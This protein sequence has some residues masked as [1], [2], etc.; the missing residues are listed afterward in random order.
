MGTAIGLVLLSALAA[1]SMHGIVRHLGQ[2]L[3]PFQIAF[4]RFALGGVILLPW[5]M[6]AG[7]LALATSRIRLH[8]LRAVLN[9]AAL[10]CFFTALTLAPLAQLVALNFT[11]PL[12]ASLLAIVMLR[13]RIRLRRTLGLAAGFAGMLV[14]LRPDLGIGPGPA[15]TLVSSLLWAMAM[16]TIRVSGAHRIQPCQHLLC[17]ASSIPLICLP[18]AIPVW[19]MPDAGQLG[20][21]AVAAGLGTLATPGADPGLPAGRGGASDALRL[22]QADLGGGDRLGGVRGKA[23]G[24]GAGGRRDHPGRHQL[25]RLARDAGGP[26]RPA[27]PR[28][29]RAERGS[30][31]EAGADPLQPQIL[32]GA[33]HLLGAAGPADRTPRSR[34][35]GSPLHAGCRQ[36]W[37]G[38]FSTGSG[39]STIS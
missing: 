29:R 19:R 4:L 15:L 20:L 17:Q 7:R 12:F 37:R 28:P 10:L 24:L 27:G 3:H 34:R 14:I 5:L 9:A 33:D 39:V 16:T 6:R 8:L 2:S 25:C 13:E 22:Y 32:D 38:S 30:G 11:A 1:V 21:L 26:G 31:R 23:G 18:L 35:R 36:R